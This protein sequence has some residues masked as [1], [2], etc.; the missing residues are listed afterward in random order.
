[1]DL[2]SSIDR[3]LDALALTVGMKA[4]ADV[5]SVLSTKVTEIEIHGS[6]NAQ[7]AAKGVKEINDRMGR[8]G[9]QIAGAVG[10]AALSMIGTLII[11]LLKLRN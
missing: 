6:N 3:K 7:E 8:M 4:N 10:V 11:G 1:M 9:W 2:F 5:L